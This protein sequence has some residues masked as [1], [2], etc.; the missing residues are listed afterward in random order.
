MALRR[1]L[2]ET[3]V[4]GRSIERPTQTPAS[5]RRTNDTMSFRI[6][7]TLAALSTLYFLA[8]PSFAQ[9][10][11]QQGCTPGYWKTH[12]ESWDGIGDDFTQTIFS[13]LSF[14]GVM[15]VTPQQSGFPDSLT[16]IEASA[17][18]GGDR[19]AL[20]RHAAAGLPSA[21]A[22]ACYSYTVAEVIGIYRDGIGVDPGVLSIEQAKN[23]LDTANNLGTCPLPSR[24]STFCFGEEG[25][26][27][28]GNTSLVGGC[29][30]STGNGGV[31]DAVSGSASV[32]ADDLVLAASNLPVGNFAIFIAAEGHKATPFLDGNLCVGGLTYKTVRH[33]A[34][35]VVPP[36]GVLTLGPGI[37]ATSN[38]N[39]IGLPAIVG[40][41][42][43]ES[44]FFQTYY[45][46]PSGPCGTQANL[47]NAVAVTFY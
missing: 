19:N 31:L 15:G 27:P 43:G 34:P 41:D 18:Q 5:T 14:N 11:C 2:T 35:T 24:V 4:T 26:C 25:A 8:A 12:P 20:S 38:S 44:W 36:S 45:R 7:G 17:L 1:S 46:D 42:A 23:L 16:L 6:K 13:F 22:L 29:A 39:T 33:S 10:D 37:V 47:T 32:V 3:L 21:D 40:I 30:N 28:C 9:V